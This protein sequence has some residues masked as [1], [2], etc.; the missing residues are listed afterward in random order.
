[1][2]TKQSINPGWSFTLEDA[3]IPQQIK[4]EWQT[5]DLPHTWNK[6]D[7]QDGRAYHRGIG[8]Y[9]KEV[10]FGE[11]KPGSQVY[12]E[13]PAASLSAEIFVNGEKAAAHEGGFSIFRANITD[14]IHPGKNLIAIQVDN[15][16]KSNIY[17]QMAD[18]TFYGGLYRGVNIIIVP[19]THFS[20]DFK[21]SEG[22]SVSSKIEGNTA[23]FDLNCWITNPQKGDSVQFTVT[24]MEGK[25]VAEIV[26]SADAHVQG[27]LKLE[28]PHKWQGIDDP[29]LYTATATLR[30]HNE[31]LDEVSVRH[32]IREYFVD[33]QKGFY[34]NG[35]LTPLRG[36]S[37]HQDQLDKG[38]AL[39]YEDHKKDADI[40]R[41]LGANTIRLAHYQ[42][43]QDFYDLCD[44]YGFVVW[45]EIPFISSMNKDPRAHDNAKSQMEELVYQNYNHSSILF[46]GISN[47][48]TIG[49]ETE[50]LNNNLNELNDM[51]HDMDKTRLT[52]MAQVSMLPMDSVENDITDILSYNHYFGWYS[53]KMEDNEV[54]FD[55]FHAMHPDRAVGISEYGC[56]GIV[57][58]HNDHPEKGDYSEEYQALYH[59][60]MAKIIDERPWLWATHIWNMFDFGCGARDE[61][62]VK[63]RNN[64]GLATIDRKIKKDSYYLYKAYWSKEPF[65]HIT[66]KRWAKRPMEATDIKVYSNQPYVG[67][68]DGDRKIGELSGEKVFV[69]KDIPLHEG[70][71]VFT[72]RAGEQSDTIYIEKTEEAAPEYEL[73]IEPGSQGVTN[74]FDEKEAEGP[75]T[76][77]DAY[78]SIN[79]PIG[80]L[81][82]DPNVLPVLLDAISSLTGMTVKIGM[83]G[84]LKDS[85]LDDLARMGG[86]EFDDR[87]KGILNEA[88]Q[89]IKKPE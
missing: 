16:E 88:L 69:F 41:D 53:G 1:M 79:D 70:M 47:E 66:S 13:V 7:G 17:P 59:E 45:A 43:S 44:E 10:D 3:G 76:F 87:K 68:Y 71:N 80:I 19:E 74:W 12:I 77:D 11:L 75:L 22:F 55:K 24:D 57:D 15:A 72:A 81:K 5:I 34:L 26:K 38:Y 8:T 29:Y 27:E 67:L 20:L 56:E 64:K 84:M 78:Y 60:H 54:W 4:P 23:V 14:L 86:T 37:R 85:K 89:K 83:L 18:F 62:G 28:E 49:G 33:P 61:G 46:W 21:G 39:T 36:V 9:A 30:R 52:T 2:R 25:T 65:V 48:I 50:Q 82:D 51:V 35:I 40:I 63:G 31:V 58:Y 42:H 6:Y 73:F 32:G